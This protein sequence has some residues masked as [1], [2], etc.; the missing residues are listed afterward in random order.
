MNHPSVNHLKYPSVNHHLLI[1]YPSVINWTT[2]I[3]HHLLIL[4]NHL[5]AVRGPRSVNPLGSHLG[6][7]GPPVSAAHG[8]LPSSQE[9]GEDGHRHGTRCRV[10]RV[11]L[12][13]E[14]VAEPVAWLVVDMAMGQ[15]Q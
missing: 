7:T 9:A 14:T 1:T 8:G 15:S 11:S 10:Q 13:Q 6:T 12:G 4:T 5:P 3:Y 2:I